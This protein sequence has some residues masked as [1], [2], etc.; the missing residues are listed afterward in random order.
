MTTKTERQAYINDLLLRLSGLVRARELLE[1]RDASDAELVETDAQ[2]E[3]LHWQLARI[4]QAN[5]RLE[6]AA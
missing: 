2:I 5:Q 1:Y 3:Q 4:V 6:R